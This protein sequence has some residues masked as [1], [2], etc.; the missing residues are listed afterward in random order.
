MTSN[1][2]LPEPCAQPGWPQRLIE[3]LETALDLYGELDRLA[4]EQARLI[5]DDDTQSILDILARR[6]PVIARLTEQSERLRPFDGAWPVVLGE[7][8]DTTRVIVEQR[9]DTLGTISTRIAEQ[10]QRV[11]DR[12]EMRRDAMRDELAGL[13]TGKNAVGAYAPSAESNPKFQDREA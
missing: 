4:A 6:E 8:D 11:R 3:S 10:D 2:G 7:L 1:T 9:L 12:L 5:D 13:S